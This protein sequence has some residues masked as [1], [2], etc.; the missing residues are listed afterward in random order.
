MLLG[1]VQREFEDYLKCGRLEDGFLRV[2]CTEC[3]QERWW[4][5]AASVGDSID[6]K[7]HDGARYQYLNGRFTGSCCRLSVVSE[8]PEL[9]E[10]DH[11]EGPH[12]EPANF[13]LLFVRPSQVRH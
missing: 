8:G 1:Y 13:R 6:A 9:A 5:S 11:C 7:G 2:R 4:R 12:S 3:H 10:S